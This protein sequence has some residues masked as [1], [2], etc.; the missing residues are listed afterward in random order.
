VVLPLSVLG[1]LTPEERADCKNE[2]V[3]PVVEGGSLTSMSGLKHPKR[4]NKMPQEA[5]L[6]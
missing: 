3:E 1:R 4:K 2:D 6:V 5:T